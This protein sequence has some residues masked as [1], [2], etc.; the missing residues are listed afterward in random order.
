MQHANCNREI[1]IYEGAKH[2]L[3]KETD[4]VKKSVMKEI[5]TWIF[6]RVK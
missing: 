5:E 6:N 1:K 4:E 2:H 3:H